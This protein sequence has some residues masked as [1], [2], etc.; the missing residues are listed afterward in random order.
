MNE[1]FETPFSCGCDP[2]TSP[3]MVEACG[4]CRANQALTCEEEAILTRMRAI[5]DQVRSISHRMKQLGTIGSGEVSASSGG[6]HDA[7]WQEL[8]SQLNDLRGKWSEWQGRLDEAIER[9][10]ILLGHRDPV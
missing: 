2:F 5:K 7:E 9:K 3:E 6:E 1:H 4:P 8:T 10:L